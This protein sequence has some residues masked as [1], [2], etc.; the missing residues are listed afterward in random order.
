MSKDDVG[1]FRGRRRD[2]RVIDSDRCA[3]V[4]VPRKTDEFIYDDLIEIE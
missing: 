2:N 4:T 1:T 3:A